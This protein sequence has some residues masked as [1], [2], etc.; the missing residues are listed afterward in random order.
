MWG[1]A[2]IF[3]AATT[4]LTSGEVWAIA[5]A[6]GLVGYGFAVYSRRVTGSYPW[7]VPALIWGLFGVLVPVISLILEAVARLTTC[8]LPPPVADPFSPAGYRSA[9]VAL[10][11]PRA[12]PTRRHR[13][14]GVAP[15]G[16]PVATAGDPPVAAARDRSVTARCEAERHRRGWRAAVAGRQPRHACS[17]PMAASSRPGG[18]PAAAR[19]GIPSG[20]PIRRS[21]LSLEHV[22]ASAGPGIPGACPGG[23]GGSGGLDP[24]V[25]LRARPDAAAAVRLVPR[26]HGPSRGALLGRPALVTPGIRQLRAR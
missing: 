24:A 20:S 16:S 8:P 22:A 11:G 14:S 2:P 4:T 13:A 5:A 17:A 23:L 12:P 10:R 1:A 6:S 25:A 21:R 7:R 19:P 15:A 9:P 3:A 26:S 18:V